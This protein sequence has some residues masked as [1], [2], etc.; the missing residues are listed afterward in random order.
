MLD[1]IGSRI[2]EPAGKG[3]IDNRQAF[4]PLLSNSLV[5]MSGW[6]DLVANAYSSPEGMAKETWMMNDSIV[7]VNG[8]F[9]LNCSFQNMLGDPITLLFQAWLT[10]MGAVYLGTMSPYIISLIEN[11]IDY[12]TRVYRFVLDY[13]GRFIQKWAC[14]GVAMPTSL[15]IGSSFDMDRANPFSTSVDQVSMSFACIGAEYNDPVILDDFNKTVITQNARMADGA[16][17]EDY[18]KIPR[19]ERNLFNYNG[20]PRV[21]LKNNELEWWIDK[22]IYAAYK[23]G[24]I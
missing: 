9:D 8:R 16:R 1:P 4:L 14:C 3:L 10:Y 6:P 23:K 13:S 22:D 18:V 7:K 15:N 21:N 20:Y 12:M 19:D 5:S 24:D 17:Q 2:R 11:E